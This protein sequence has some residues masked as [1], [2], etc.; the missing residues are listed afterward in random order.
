[1]IRRTL[2]AMVFVMSGFAAGMVLTGRMRTAEEA[3]AAEP[4]APRVVQPAAP[5]GIGTMPDLS[6]VASRAIPSVMN[7]SSLQVVRQQVSPFTSDPLFRYFFG[8]D[9]TGPRNRISQSLGSGVM[10]SQDGYILTNNHVVGDA[11]AQ[12]SVVLPDKRELKAKIVGVDEFTD[13]ALLK[14]D[15]HGQPVLPWGDSSK[16]KV[17]EWVLAIGNPSS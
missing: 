17:A 5:G 16:L 2:L 3:H 9:M 15:A 8:D 11:R 1:M 4:P 10:V 7:I 13:L 14:I 12:V 6:A